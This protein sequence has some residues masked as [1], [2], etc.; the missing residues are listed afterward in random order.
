MTPWLTIAVSAVAV[1]CVG[2]ILVGVGILSSLRQSRV[3]IS[4]AMNGFNETNRLGFEVQQISIERLE[5][6]VKRLEER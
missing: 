2:L 4:M 1:G 3:A 6:R 5:A